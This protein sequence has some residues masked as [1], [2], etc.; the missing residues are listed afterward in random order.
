M[1]VNKAKTPDADSSRD[2]HAQRPSPEYDPQAGRGSR[3]T[4]DPDVAHQDE[5]AQEARDR[6]DL[7]PPKEARTDPGR[8]TGELGHDSRDPDV[9]LTN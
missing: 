1:A 2:V 3:N 5:R 4:T 7:S 9:P 8:G 6:A